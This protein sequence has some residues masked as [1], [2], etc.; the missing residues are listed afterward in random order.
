MIHVFVPLVLCTSCNRLDHSFLHGH[1]QLSSRYGRR[2]S[3]AT[4]LFISTGHF[5]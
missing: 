4:L 1:V 5:A 2:L 3:I